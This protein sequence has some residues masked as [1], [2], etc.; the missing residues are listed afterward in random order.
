MVTEPAGFLRDTLIKFKLFSFTAPKGWRYAKDDTLPVVG[1][2]TFRRRLHNENGK[3][4]YFEYG[5]S[6]FGERFSPCPIPAY[7]RAEYL[8]H[9]F[10]TSGWLFSDDP[11]L[12]DLMLQSQHDISSLKIAGLTA[13]V[14]KPKYYK[15]GY[16]GIYIDSTDVLA[17][18]LV[19]FAIY[20]ENLDSLENVQLMKTVNTLEIRPF[21]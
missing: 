21:K 12:P 7:R 15:K 1:D 6:T 9:K 18:N 13:F 19:Q 5:L 14:Y 16:S 17:G 10:D 20:G 4:I 3:L 2:A 11:R 8:D